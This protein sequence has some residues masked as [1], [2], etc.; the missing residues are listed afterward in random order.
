MNLQSFKFLKLSWTSQKCFDT[1]QKNIHQI[2]FIYLLN[3]SPINFPKINFLTLETSRVSFSLHIFLTSS[4]QL[5]IYCHDISN[6]FFYQSRREAKINFDG[7]ARKAVDIGKLGFYGQMRDKKF[8]CGGFEIFFQEMK[9]KSLRKK[10]IEA[11]IFF[12]WLPT[13]FILRRIFLC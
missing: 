5:K 13:N 11:I 3:P 10:L 1:T 2:V 4:H 8:L 12:I 6:W 7:D 9:I